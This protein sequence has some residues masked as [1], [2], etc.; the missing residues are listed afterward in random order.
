MSDLRNAIWSRRHGFRDFAALLAELGADTR[1][2][3]LSLDFI[4]DDARV[5]VGTA[6]DPETGEDTVFRA[7][8]PEAAWR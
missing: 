1:G 4:S 6:Y 3:S 2:A 7:Q 5:I 8:L